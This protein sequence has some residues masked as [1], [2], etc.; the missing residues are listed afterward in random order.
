MN[1]HNSWTSFWGVGHIRVG[2]ILYRETVVRDFLPCPADE[3]LRASTT[4]VVHQE[5]AMRSNQGD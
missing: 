5:V 2:V 3:L 1:F 4:R